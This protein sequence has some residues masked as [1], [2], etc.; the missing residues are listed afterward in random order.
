MCGLHYQLLACGKPHTD[1]AGPCDARNPSPL[2]C[3]S[4][5]VH[6]WTGLHSS[7]VILLHPPFVV[8]ATSKTHTR[9]SHI[10]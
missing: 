5:A 3:S 1:P 4:S 6:A 10:R 7:H 2:H 8:V 9:E